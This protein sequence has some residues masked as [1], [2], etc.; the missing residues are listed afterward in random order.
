MNRYNTD[1]VVDG[2]GNAQNIRFIIPLLVVITAIV[3]AVIIIG[4]DSEVSSEKNI[5]PLDTSQLDFTPGVSSNVL[6]ISSEDHI[7]G[8]P[9]APVKV[10]EFSD[11]ECPFC[12]TF[13]SVMWKIMDT[14]GKKGKVA[15][16]YRHFPIDSVHS[17][18]RKEATAAEC[19]GEVG[20]NTAFWD[21][22]NRIFEITPSNNGLNLDLLPEIADYINIDVS[23]FEECLKSKN[24]E[25]H[26][27]DNFRDAVNSGANG[28]PYSII[29]APNGKTFPLSGAQTYSAVSAVIDLALKER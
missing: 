3:L 16:I 14:Y 9:N 25:K 29:V 11:F 20:G 17:K 8:N 10:I 7:L 19:A 6:P 26:I 28:T 13:H 15:W 18:A 22:A 23:A 12:K 5:S 27:E 4:K 2:A 1:K 24:Y 21:Y